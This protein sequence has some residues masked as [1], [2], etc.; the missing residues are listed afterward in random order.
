MGAKFVLYAGDWNVTINPEI[1][2]RS[3][4]LVNDLK[5]EKF[6][7]RMTTEGLVDVWRLNNRLLLTICLTMAQLGLSLARQKGSGEEVFGDSTTF[8]CLIPTSWKV[9]IL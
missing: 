4:L 5:P 6:K 2:N 9:P 1:D 7:N 3:Y 8:S